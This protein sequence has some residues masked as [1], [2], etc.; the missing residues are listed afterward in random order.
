MPW[1]SR[2]IEKSE[3][4]RGQRSVKIV[5]YISTHPYNSRL[6]YVASSLAGLV[7]QLRPLRTQDRHTFPFRVGALIDEIDRE[8]SCESYN[9]W[10]LDSCMLSFRPQW[11]RGAATCQMVQEANMDVVDVLKAGMFAMNA[12]RCSDKGHL[13]VMLDDVR[14]FDDQLDSAASEQNASDTRS[15]CQR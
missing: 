1:S 2:R 11:W 10:P 7:D 14:G 13:M 4:C 9:E 12:R 8:R 6:V 15:R 3:R 5:R